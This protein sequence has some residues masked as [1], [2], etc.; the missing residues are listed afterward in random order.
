MKKILS[1]YNFLLVLAITAVLSACNKDDVENPVGTEPI[2]FIQPDSSTIFASAG[3]LVDFTL[4]LAIDNPIDTLRG[5]YFIDTTRGGTSIDTNVILENLTY[6]DMQT[7]FFVQG[8]ADS[9]NVQTV[10]GVLEMPLGRNDSTAFWT[11]FAGS[12][13][14]FLPAQYDAVRVVFQIEAD[15]LRYEKQLKIIVN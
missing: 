11:Y 7:E 3:E 8:F 2:N 12:T 1:P 13:T 5:A 6:A 15:T 4:Y 9:L 14:P 10:S